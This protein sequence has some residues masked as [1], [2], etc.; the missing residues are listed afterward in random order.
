[1]RTRLLLL[2]QDRIAELEEQLNEI[3]RDEPKE[4]FRATRRGDKNKERKAVVEDLEKAL[5]SFG[6]NIQQY[7]PRL[8]TYLRI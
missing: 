7:F 1:M 2:K 6:E 8:Q 5:E 4:V 3:D